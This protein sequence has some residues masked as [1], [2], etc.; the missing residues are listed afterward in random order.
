MKTRYALALMLGMA[1]SLVSADRAQAQCGLNQGLYGGYGAFDVGRLYGV[2]A[3][4]VP[5]FAAFPPVYY[6]APVPRT[7][8][9]SPFAYP[10][11]VR[12]PDL[13]AA[14]VA[15]EI[16]NPYVPVSTESEKI[17]QVTQASEV[18]RS[19]TQPLAIVNPYVTT[20]LAGHTGR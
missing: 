19:S 9:Y 11:G 14:V 17:D 12:T 5:Y 18:P 4:N 13:P 20:R 7:Y 15:Q 16:L 2:L 10:P 1:C 3:Q 6:S 8:G